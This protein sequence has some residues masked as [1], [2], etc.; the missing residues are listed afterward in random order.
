VT[1]VPGTDRRD[2]LRRAIDRYDVTSFSDREPELEEIY[3]T[4][5]EKAGIAE[6]RTIE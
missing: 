2:F 3:L 4:A 6:T 5:V 1:L